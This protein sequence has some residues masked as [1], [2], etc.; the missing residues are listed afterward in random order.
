[1]LCCC[2]CCTSVVDGIPSLQSLVC[3]GRLEP[4]LP[5]QQATAVKVRSAN[6]QV[7]CWSVC[8]MISAAVETDGA[9]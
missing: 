7:Y 4:H 2:P 8:Q 3:P 5:E 9:W 6:G 1:M